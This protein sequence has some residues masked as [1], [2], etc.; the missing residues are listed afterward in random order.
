M[1]THT[2]PSVEHVPHDELL[3]KIAALQLELNN[4]QLNLKRTQLER[5]HYK[6]QLSARIRAL[7]AARSEARAHLKQA[8]LFFNEAEMQAQAPPEKSKTVQVGAHSKKKPGRKPLDPALPRNVIRHE[9]P[10]DQRVCAHDGSTL[11]EIGVEV[12]EQ[13]DILPAILSVVRHERVKYACPCCDNTIKTAPSPKKL[14]DKG[15]LTE[16]ALAW[17]ITAK[18]QDALPLYRQATLLNRFGGDIVRHTLANNVVHVGEAVQPLINLLRDSL[19]DAAVVHGD[20]TTLQVLKESGRRA[21]QQSYLWVQ[22]TGTGPPVRLFTYAPSRSAATAKD[23]Y[24]D[25]QGAL[26][27]D[28]YEVYD[29]IARQYSLVHLACWAHARRK[30][31]EAE[32]ALPKHARTSDH[33]AIV[34]LNLIGELYGV[35]QQ[36]RE[37]GREKTTEQRLAIILQARRADSVNIVDHIQT[38]LL[39]HLHTT[40]PQSPLGKAFQYLHGQWPKL[41][42]FLDN[43]SYPLDNNLSENAIRP[44]EIG[45]KNF[46]FSDTVHGAK[47]SANLYSLIE[48]AKAN[49][50]EPYHYLAHVFRELPNATTLDNIDALLPW[51]VNIPGAGSPSSLS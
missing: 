37:A 11:L 7:Y 39:A 27:S 12:S 20:E 25:M 49:G 48:T 29:Q 3:A 14:I 35:E 22:C 46:L 5:D 24:A 2:A 51:K 28:G 8:D 42:R 26:M 40:A 21:Q 34:M 30:F 13:L 17:V 50:L 38:Q 19:A 9:L 1:S 36:A 32:A 31:I 4:T 6:L 43:G 15:L 16:N 23:L 10:Q 45:R 41:I 44:F 47:A 33:P 18:Y